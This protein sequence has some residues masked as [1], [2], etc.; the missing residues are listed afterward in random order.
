MYAM[1]HVCA[2]KP[3]HLKSVIMNEERSTKLNE[4]FTFIFKFEN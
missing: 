4:L 3:V 1:N 2:I